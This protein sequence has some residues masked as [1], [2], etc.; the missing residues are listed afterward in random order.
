MLLSNQSSD[1]HQ[2]NPEVYPDTVLHWG[3]KLIALFWSEYGRWPPW[4]SG[5]EE[6][7]LDDVFNMRVINEGISEGILGRG[8]SDGT[9]Y[10][11]NNPLSLRDIL[12]GEDWFV[13]L[14]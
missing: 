12:Q 11:I 2:G 13:L 14:L 10:F 3:I 4:C 7:D 5:V 6:A 9:L 1:L 8:G